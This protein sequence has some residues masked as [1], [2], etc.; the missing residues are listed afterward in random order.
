MEEKKKEVDG[1]RR[2]FRRRHF[3]E[4]RTSRLSYAEYTGRHDLRENAFIE[5]T[6]DETG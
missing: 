4:N 6:V 5:P 2:E 1:Q 3:A